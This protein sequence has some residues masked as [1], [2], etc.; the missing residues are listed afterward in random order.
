LVPLAALAALAYLATSQSAGS[1]TPV[2]PGG[3]SS[4]HGRALVQTRHTGGTDAHAWTRTRVA[5]A[6]QVLAAQGYDAATA[7][8]LAVALVAQWAR[9]T[10]W[11]R[12]EFNY[13]VGN[14][15]AS[16]WQGDY[17]R[18]SDGSYYRAYPTLNEGVADAI[19]LH[20]SGRYREAWEYLVAHADPVG[21]YDR[22]M[23]AG[24]H[25]WSQEALSDMSSIAARVD[26]EPVAGWSVEPWDVVG[27]CGCVEQQLLGVA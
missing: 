16:N 22:I 2:Q 18:L 20:R 21:W 3:T 7:R 25:P 11:G 17:H 4:T 8:R 10:G 14:I 19:R 1:P 9:E 24:Y 15:K 26:R 23:R 5:A 13:A 27:Y 12:A 6:Q